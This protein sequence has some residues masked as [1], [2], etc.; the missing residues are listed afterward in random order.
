MLSESFNPHLLYVYYMCGAK[1]ANE[2]LMDLYLKELRLE[3]DRVTGTVESNGEES[4]VKEVWFQSWLW[5]FPAKW[6]WVA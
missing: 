3:W 4:T 1:W 6:L 2:K 5:P